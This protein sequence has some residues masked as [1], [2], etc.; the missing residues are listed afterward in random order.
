MIDTS[1]EPVPELLQASFREAKTVRALCR[2]CPPP[3]HV[4]GL[5]RRSAA[6]MPPRAR[7]QI[8]ISMAPISVD[9]MV[10]HG[11]TRDSRQSTRSQNKL[12]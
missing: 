3:D 8:S 5:A 9:P 12:L 1:L 10:G 2:H 11:L 6:M 4:Y 7:L